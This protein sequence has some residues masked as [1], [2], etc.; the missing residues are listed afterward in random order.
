MTAREQ[1]LR[2]IQHSPE[3]LIREVLDFLLFARSRNY[4]FVEPEVDDRETP[5]QPIWEFAQELM[6]LWRTKTTMRIVF[7]DTFYWSALLNTSGEDHKQVIQFGQSNPNIKLVTN[8]CDAENG[9]F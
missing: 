8:D 2:E 9:N 4:P 1:L 7:A 3:P 5:Q 6:P